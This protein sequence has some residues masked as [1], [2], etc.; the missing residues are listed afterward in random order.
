M[1]LLTFKKVLFLL[2]IRQQNHIM[3]SANEGAHLYSRTL[4]PRLCGCTTSSRKSYFLEVGVKRGRP[5]GRRRRLVVKSNGGRSGAL[6]V[7]DA[8]PY[9]ARG[10]P[11]LHLDEVSVRDPFKTRN[12]LLRHAQ[13]CDPSGSR[14]W[15]PIYLLLLP[16]RL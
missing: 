10:R 8:C 14:H 2:D 4:A 13:C 15:A 9:R 1:R 7:G 16:S 11:V 12:A 5:N 6:H 3:N